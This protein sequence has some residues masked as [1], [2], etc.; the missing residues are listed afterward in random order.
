M[1]GLYI[2]LLGV[3]LYGSYRYRVFCFPDTPHPLEK[4]RIVAVT[5][6]FVVSNCCNGIESGHAGRTNAPPSDDDSEDFL[7]ALP[8]LATFV[9]VHY[10]SPVL[11]RWLVIS[12][13][14]EGFR[15][16][17]AQL[18]FC[19]VYL[20]YCHCQFHWEESFFCSN[21][22]LLDSHCS[23]ESFLLHFLDILYPLF[24][25]GIFVSMDEHFLGSSHR[26]YVFDFNLYCL[27]GNVIACKI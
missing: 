14:S 16:L 5:L 7:R 13:H 19:C 6:V 26:W 1:P 10:V 15:L 18:F 2:P 27:K 3:L 23:R 20:F 25:D 11:F 24:K 9:L 17:I 12:L 4:V 21:I 8:I 22:G